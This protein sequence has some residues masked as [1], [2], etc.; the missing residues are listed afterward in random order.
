MFKNIARGA[1]L[2]IAIEIFNDIFDKNIKRDDVFILA[3]KH[4]IYAFYGIFRKQLLFADD[5]VFKS[6]IVIKRA[7]IGIKILIHKEILGVRELLAQR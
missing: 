6:E 5:A 7:D 2:R 1:F 4:A 3:A